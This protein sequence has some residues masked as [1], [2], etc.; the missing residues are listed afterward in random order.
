MHIN[1]LDCILFLVPKTPMFAD[2]VAKYGADDQKILISLD[3][4]FFE[5]VSAYKTKTFNFI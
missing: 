5:V 1:Q 4:Q 2:V 3:V